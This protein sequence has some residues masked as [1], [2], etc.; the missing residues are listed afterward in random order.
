[1]AFLFAKSE[2]CIELV[3]S[4]VNNETND[5]LTNTVFTTRLRHSLRE[6]KKEKREK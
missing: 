4:D 1:M 3:K 5:I 2:V 6:G